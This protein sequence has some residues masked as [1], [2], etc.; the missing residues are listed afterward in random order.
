VNKAMAQRWVLISYLCL[1]LTL[2][3]L[4]LVSVSALNAVTLLGENWNGF[5]STWN[6][7]Q[8]GVAEGSAVATANQRVATLDA[9]VSSLKGMKAVFSGLLVLAVVFLVWIV[10]NARKTLTSHH[11]A[12]SSAVSSEHLAI[13]RLTDE[14]ELL[15]QGDLTTVA[16]D[17][18]PD[19]APV[20]E[21]VNLLVN[22]FSS[23]LRSLEMASD[24]LN[25]TLD[26]AG[27]SSDDLTDS[28]A[29]QSRL[30]HC[31]SNFLFS[32]SAS[33]SGLSADTAE[34]STVAQT[35]LEKS[36]SGEIALTA[37][38]D[39]L[40]AIQL[41]V[42]DTRQVMNRLAENIAAIDQSV[43]I[44]QD[45]AKQTDLLALN[46]TIRATG[47]SRSTS[48]KDASTD[49]GRLS[50]EVAQLA[51]VLGQ[52][53]GEIGSLA[54]IIAKDAFDT[55]KSMDLIASQIALGVAQTED[56]D[57][58]LSNLKDSSSLLHSRI[59]QMTK[60]S[61]EQSGNVRRLIE[62][63]DAIN[64]ITDQTVE[65]FTANDATLAD[66]RQ[67]ASDL[68]HKVDEFQ[69]PEKY[70]KGSNTRHQRKSAARRA[71]NRAVSV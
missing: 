14:L 7:M 9:L 23:V 4:I 49:L 67:L 64:Q 2:L 8:L 20:A 71:A 50:D 10:W 37:M 35:M 24:Q 11:A 63:A 53:T 32:M 38:L 48:M 27:R 29:E 46:T 45:L 56:A 6:D 70:L 16:S 30:I 66:L 69:L 58:A 39:K 34:C 57:I 36:E 68:K 61:V 52:A 43:V 26:Q 60:S 41:E 62:N 55:V 59:Q 40:S 33:M 3:A 31:C 5:Q 65:G 22:E 19:T 21:S 25:L 28:C 12:T 15:T 42:D 47:S 13:M 44:V 51:D 1:A 54:K 17:L 18:D